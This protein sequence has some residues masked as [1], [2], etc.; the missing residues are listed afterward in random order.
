MLILLNCHGFAKTEMAVES[1]A[2][3][4]WRAP[5]PLAAVYATRAA[6]ERDAMAPDISESTIVEY[7]ASF[8]INV[9]R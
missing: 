9:K 5:V 6:D 1:V 2:L 4:I 7:L 3:R 8:Q